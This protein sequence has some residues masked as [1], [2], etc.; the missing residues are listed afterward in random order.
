MSSLNLWRMRAFYTA[1]QEPV[2]YSGHKR[3]DR[4]STAKAYPPACDR[5]CRR[6]PRTDGLSD[7]GTQYQYCFINSKLNAQTPFGDMEASLALPVRP[8]SA[9]MKA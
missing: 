2:E 5:I 4:I 6:A 9:P 1:Y 8:S 7:L 3:C